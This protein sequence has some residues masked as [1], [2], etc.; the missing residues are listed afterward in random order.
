MRLGCGVS[1]PADEARLRQVFDNVVGNAVKYTPA[2]GRVELSTAVDADEVVI[3]VADTG[4]GVPAAERPRL[5]EKLYRSTSAR[6]HGIEGT[7][8]GL[9]VTKSLVEAH[10]GT[11][12]AAGNPGGGTVFTVRLPWRE[13]DPG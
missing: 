8:L 13:P 7:G 10:G 11:V 6:E 4:I 12:S 3:R 1:V 2:G 9:S 5:F